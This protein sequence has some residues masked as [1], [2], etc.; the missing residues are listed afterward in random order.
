MSDNT[1]LRGFLERTGFDWTTGRILIVGTK[2]EWPDGTTVDPVEV[3]VA[4]DL[5]S[6]DNPILDKVFYSGYGA[7]ECPHYIA[8][9]A[10]CYYFP[11]QYDGSTAPEKLY[12]NI[13]RYLTLGVT[14]PPFPGGG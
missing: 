12:K 11:S 7:N 1:T 2:L 14:A 4:A 3:V 10:E 6:F 8:E 5:I 9:D 13:E